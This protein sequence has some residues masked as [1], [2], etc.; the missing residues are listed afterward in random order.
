MDHHA[1][2]SSRSGNERENVQP[3]YNTIKPYNKT[4]VIFVLFVSFVA[5][6][7]NLRE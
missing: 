5:K 4:F 2:S 7:I 3:L 1:M 6:N